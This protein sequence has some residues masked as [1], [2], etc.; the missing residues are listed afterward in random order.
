LRR[1]LDGAVIKGTVGAWA[2]ENKKEQQ[3]V[4]AVH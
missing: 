1:E 3:Q 2:L 4:R